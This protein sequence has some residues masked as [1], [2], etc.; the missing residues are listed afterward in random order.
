M[1]TFLLHFNKVHHP[2]HHYHYYYY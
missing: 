2:H 1:K